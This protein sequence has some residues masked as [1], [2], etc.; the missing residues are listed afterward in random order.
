[1]KKLILTLAIVSMFVG[2]A[3]IANPGLNGKH[4][5]KKNGADSVNC[6]YCHTKAGLPKTKGQDLA[7]LKSTNGSCKAA[8]CH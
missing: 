2:G 8:G 4:A 6:V 5:G 1:M 7:K 3:A